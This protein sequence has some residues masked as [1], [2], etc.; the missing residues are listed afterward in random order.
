MDKG[1]S[2]T[3]Q[4]ALFPF[5]VVQGFDSAF[6]GINPDE[7]QRMDPQHRLCLMGKWVGG[8][9]FLRLKQIAEL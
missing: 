1:A 2:K 4:A 5:E 7:A 3:S 8:C 9:E 6:F